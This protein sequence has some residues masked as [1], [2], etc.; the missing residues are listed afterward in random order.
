ML[1]GIQGFC[2]TPRLHLVMYNTLGVS[3]FF[4]SFRLGIPVNK[5]GA[6]ISRFASE[7]I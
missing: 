6:D 3:I 7:K 4:F 1:D 5:K 2:G